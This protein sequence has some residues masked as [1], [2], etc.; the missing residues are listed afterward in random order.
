MKGIIETGEL[1]VRDRKESEAIGDKNYEDSF[2]TR[3]ILI[4]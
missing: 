2:C 4:F 3:I 1:V